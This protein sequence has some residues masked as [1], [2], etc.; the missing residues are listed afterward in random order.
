MHQPGQH[1]SAPPLFSHTTPKFTIFLHKAIKYGQGECIITITAQFVL[2]SQVLIKVCVFQIMVEEGVGGR[3]HWVYISRLLLLL[4]TP[5][6]AIH[7][8]KTNKGPKEDFLRRRRRYLY[9]CGAVLDF[10]PLF[11][12]IFPFF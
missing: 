3:L 4:S 7:S 10:S 12:I 5:R 1:W 6:M 11:Y 9:K 8:V 2:T